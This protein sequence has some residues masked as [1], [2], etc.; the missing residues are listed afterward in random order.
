MPSNWRPIGV[1][2]GM[3]CG[4]AVM[5]GS[6]V[7]QVGAPTMEDFEAA[8]PQFREEVSGGLIEVAPEE[9][10]RQNVE[11]D[12]PSDDPRDFNGMY[13]RLSRPGENPFARPEY[14]EGSILRELPARPRNLGERACLFASFPG[15]SSYSTTI[16]QNEDSIVF[17]MEENHGLRWARFADSRDYTPQ[18]SYQGDSIARWQGDTLVIDTVA[19]KVEGWERMLHYVEHFRKNDDGNI[20]IEQ[21]VME[22]GGALTPVGSLTLRW[23]PDLFYVE[24]IC[25]D[26]G[27]EFG[28]GYSE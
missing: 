9:R 24:D 6:A 18:G 12:P 21:F 2:V 16:V 4:L 8:P 25:E 26:L 10:V 22:L 14:P 28:V 27:E 17:L 11:G 5:P 15:L 19:V 20:E 1:L 23:R 3:A 13:N 7:A